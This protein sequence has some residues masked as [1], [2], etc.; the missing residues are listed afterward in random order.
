M[1][2]IFSN[3]LLGYNIQLF[4]A[5]LKE[6]IGGSYAHLRQFISDKGWKSPPCFSETREKHSGHHLK[7]AASELKAAY[8]LLREFIVSLYGEDPEE[9]PARAMMLLFDVCDIARELEKW[10]LSAEGATAFP[11]GLGRRPRCYLQVFVQAHE[12]EAV[13]FKHHQLL[14]LEQ[15]VVQDCGL[16]NCWVVERK[17]KRTIQAMA[18]NSSVM[19]IEQTGLS[20]CLNYQLELLEHPSWLPSLLGRSNE[21]PEM[22][23]HLEANNANIARGLEWYGASLANKDFVFL[24][25]E[26]S[27]LYLVVAGIIYDDKAGIMVRAC[28]KLSATSFSSRWRI[29]PEIKFKPLTSHR[30][31]KVQ[32]SRHVAEDVVEV[33]H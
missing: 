7:A 4:M 3:G 15:Q 31:W 29:S 32:H 6:D 21:F 12:A 14:H 28:Q 23:G 26:R 13:I 20:R 27:T 8:P 16:L 22:A 11:R 33:L 17:H 5:R 1:H 24:A 25:R 9:A 10:L 2:I 19:R 18:H 30:A